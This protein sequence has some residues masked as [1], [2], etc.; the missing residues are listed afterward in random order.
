MRSVFD[1]LLPS[2]NSFGLPIL[3]HIGCALAHQF[4]I[5]DILI[6]VCVW[7]ATLDSHWLKKCC[8]ILVFLSEY[9]IR[10]I[11]RFSLLEK[12]CLQGVW[13]DISISLRKFNFEHRISTS[14]F[15]AILCAS[16]WDT[17]SRIFTSS[18]SPF[19]LRAKQK[20]SLFI[21]HPNWFYLYWY[22]CMHS[23]Q[24]ISEP[25]YKR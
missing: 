1:F 24:W 5:D 13:N 10:N 20:L 17:R 8:I 15:C 3:Y 12:T 16:K 9:K 25:N 4:N 6:N 18:N 19:P 11:Q 14:V 7:G 23:W 2:N 21:I 22:V